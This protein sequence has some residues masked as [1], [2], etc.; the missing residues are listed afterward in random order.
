MSVWSG[1]VISFIT[2]PPHSNVFTTLDELT[3]QKVYQIGLIAHSAKETLVK[4]N[5]PQLW[6]RIVD[7]ST[8]D[9]TVLITQFHQHQWKI[10]NEDYV[11]IGET[12]GAKRL[13]QKDCHITFAKGIYLAQAQHA[14]GMQ[15]NSAYIDLIDKFLLRLQQYG[16]ANF[17]HKRAHQD[18]KTDTSCSEDE[19]IPMVLRLHH[20]QWWMYL[21]LMFLSLAFVVF[22]VEICLHKMV[23][24]ACF[25]LY[26]VKLL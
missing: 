17:W 8:D 5:Y 19:N 4:Q 16:L 13:K 20:F 3:S 24:H 22:I 9:P 26:P 11:Y 21:F 23:Q 2:R 1:M 25:I 15:K 18:E 7:F 14:V 10:S 6:N 12:I